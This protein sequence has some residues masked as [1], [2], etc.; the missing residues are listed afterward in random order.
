[1]AATKRYCN[2]NSMWTAGV[3]D[4]GTVHYRYGDA[5]CFQRELSWYATVRSTD[6]NNGPSPTIVLP[7]IARAYLSAASSVRRTRRD[8][9]ANFEN[10]HRFTT[11]VVLDFWK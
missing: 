3:G 11:A 1:M 10:Y 8:A 4:S 6:H 2:G 7:N 5:D 9:A